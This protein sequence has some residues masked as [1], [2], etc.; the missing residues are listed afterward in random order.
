MKR[1]TVQIYLLRAAFSFPWI[2]GTP[3]S[4]RQE[5]LVSE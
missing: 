3:I 4:H 2:G 5:L 1:Q